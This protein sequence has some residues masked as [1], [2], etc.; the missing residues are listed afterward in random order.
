MAPQRLEKI[1]SAPGNGMAPATSTPNIWYKSAT[2]DS[3]STLAPPT[4]DAALQVQGSADIDGFGPAPLP[5]PRV[6]EAKSH[7]AA[8]SH[9]ALAN[10]DAGEGEENYPGCKALKNHK[11]GK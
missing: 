3:P 2:A 10:V 1:E 8:P 7:L 5:A 4:H 11:T 9:V 6:A